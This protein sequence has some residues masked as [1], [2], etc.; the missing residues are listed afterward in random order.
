LRASSSKPLA[1]FVS[2]T[3]ADHDILGSAGRIERR[4]QRPRAT[5]PRTTTS[6]LRTALEVVLENE[7]KPEWDV[8]AIK[9]EYLELAGALERP[10]PLSYSTDGIP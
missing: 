7:P 1:P 10:T 8:F 6:Q 2:Q 3:E 4:A 5:E 9:Y